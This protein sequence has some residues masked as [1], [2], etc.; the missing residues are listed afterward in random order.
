MAE[1]SCPR[2]NK[3]SE[4]TVTCQYCGLNFDEYETAKQEKLIEV[5]VLLSENKYHEAK[6]LA[7][8]LPTE[9]PDNRTD[10]LLLLSNINRD[11]SIV[12]KYEQAHKSY[13]AGEFEQASLLLRNI[14]AFDHNLNE[15]VISLRRKAE[16][17]LQNDDNF[18]KAVEAFDLGNYTEAKNMF[19]KV[20]GPERQEE[21]SG[22]LTRISEVSGSMLEEA[23]SCIRNK[24]FDVALDKFAAL[25]TAFP[26][27]QEETEVYVTLLIKR[28]EIKDDILHAAKQAKKEKRLLESKILY[29]FLGQQFPEFL[30]QVQPQIKEIG[31][32]VVISL[33]DLEECAMIGLP[34]LGLDGSGE[35]KG[36][37]YAAAD[38]KE[39][40]A[41]D[42]ITP[43]T[44]MEGSEDIAAVAGNSS[45][46]AD[47][48][49]ALLSVDEEGVPDFSF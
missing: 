24:Q 35:A 44:N 13:D 43:D 26:D 36:R 7:E 19:K 15:K 3:K 1:K 41:V 42:A 39:S 37:K 16:R 22:Y 9:F 27:I 18:S 11:I 14:K 47:T 46:A 25:Q 2:C 12:E 40:V 32:E 21:V 10:F 6:K 29:S 4:D 38:S 48:V 31:Q 30:S 45:S 34:G 33:A 20:Y 49:A 17:Y 23:I 5:R 8:K 28:L